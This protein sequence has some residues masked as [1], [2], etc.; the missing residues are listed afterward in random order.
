MPAGKLDWEGAVKN[1]AKYKNMI[2][3]QNNGQY[4][5][6]FLLHKQWILKYTTKS[7]TPH[8]FVSHICCIDI[9]AVYYT[10]YIRWG[11]VSCTVQNI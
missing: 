4:Y 6:S 2:G 5:Y 9:G 10:L 7:Q 11:M 8:A 1:L 3:L